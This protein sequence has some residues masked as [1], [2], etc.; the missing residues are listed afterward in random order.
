LRSASSG[1]H[2][3]TVSSSRSRHSSIRTIAAETA[4]GLEVEA[5]RKM[6]SRCIGAP[7]S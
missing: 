4:T 5:I 3:S 2:W 7:P 6:V 1:S